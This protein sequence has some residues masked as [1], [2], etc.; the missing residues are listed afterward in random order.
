MHQTH[1]LLQQSAHFDMESLTCLLFVPASDFLELFSRFCYETFL[2]FWNLF[3]N[4]LSLFFFVNLTLSKSLKYF[5]RF[6]KFPLCVFLTSRNENN[7][8]NCQT[9]WQNRRMLGIC[10]CS[11]VYRFW[12]TSLCLLTRESTAVSL[13]IGLQNI[14]RHL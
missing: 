3:F 10:L 11:F 2:I 4:I 8:Q 6:G 12:Y 1:F 13:W 9:F 7:I 5:P 14:N